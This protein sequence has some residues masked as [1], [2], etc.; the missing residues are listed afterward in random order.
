MGHQSKYQLHGLVQDCSISIALASL[1]LSHLA[2]DECFAYLWRDILEY[3]DLQNQVSQ[4]LCEW[5]RV[6]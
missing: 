4:D 1:A 2:I 5:H 6:G 3:G